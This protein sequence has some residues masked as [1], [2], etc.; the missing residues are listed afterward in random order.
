MMFCRLASQVWVGCVGMDICLDY[1]LITLVADVDR[2]EGQ[3]YG[4]AADTTGKNRFEAPAL[5]MGNS[6]WQHMGC[7]IV[8]PL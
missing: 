3:L 1:L 6:P 2:T 7:R 5:C 8:M 4:R